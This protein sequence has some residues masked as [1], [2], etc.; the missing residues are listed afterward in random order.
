MKINFHSRSTSAE[1]KIRLLARQHGVDVTRTKLDDWTDKI[2]ELSG[3]TEGS[4]DEVEQILINLRRA[5]IIS[6]KESQEL[7]LDYLDTKFGY[8]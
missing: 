8:R 7:L 6:A 3:Q 2:G 5:S 1:G 4:A